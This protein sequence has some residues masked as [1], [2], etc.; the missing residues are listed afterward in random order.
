VLV[1]EN[2][3]DPR[4]NRKEGG[5]MCLDMHGKELWRT[6]EDPYFGRGHALLAGDH[7]LIQDGFDGTLR[8]VRASPK[9]YEQVA[10]TN[11]FPDNTTRDGQ[12]WAPMAVAGGHLVLRSQDEL[13]C[14]RL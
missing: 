8:V 14:V 9:G 3:N 10:Q 11:L 7:L 2:W 4:N 5:L 1:N 12:M 6:G 13:V